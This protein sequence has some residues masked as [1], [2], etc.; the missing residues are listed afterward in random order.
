MQIGL[1]PESF[2]S[3]TPW[4]FSV[5]LKAAM[6][7]AKSKFDDM[8]WSVWHTEALARSKKLPRLKEFISASEVSETNDEKNKVRNIDEGAIIARLRGYNKQLE[9]GGKK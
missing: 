2:W 9:R 6:K 3:I 7:V 8:A 5:C 4:Q 1:Q